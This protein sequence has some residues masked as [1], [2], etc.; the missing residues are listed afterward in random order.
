MTMPA[1]IFPEVLV[2]YRSPRPGPTVRGKE[3]GTSVAATHAYEAWR[4]HHSYCRRCGEQDWHE[5]GAPRLESE[6]IPGLTTVLR[7]DGRADV[8]YVNGPDLKVL[9]HEGARLFRGWQLAAMKQDNRPDGR[10]AAAGL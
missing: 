5:P 9:C 8:Y 4:E 3:A 1:S 7:L 10:P 6:P 2:V